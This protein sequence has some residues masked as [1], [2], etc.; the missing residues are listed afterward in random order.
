MKNFRFINLLGVF[1]V[2]LTLIGT[3]V[4]HASAGGGGFIYTVTSV[5][6]G[7][8]AN[9][10]D[11]ICDA[12]PGPG[13]VCTF[14]AAIEEANA[15]AAINTIFF[16]LPG[17]GMHYLSLTG[18][19]LPNIIAPLSIYG[20]SQPNCTV[21]CIVLSGASLGGTNDGLT[22]ATNGNYVRGLDIVSFGGAGINIMF[23]NGSLPNVIESNYIGFIPGEVVSHGNGEGIQTSASALN[24]V[25]GGTTASQRNVISGNIY[26]GIYLEGEATVVGNYI[27]TTPAGNAA[28]PNGRYGIAIGIDGSMNKI[29]GV[30]A[31]SGNIIAYNHSTGIAISNISNVHPMQNSIRRNSIFSNGGLGIDLNADGV[32]LNDLGDADV[33][34][35]GL[36][37]YPVLTGAVSSTKVIS[38]HLNS[39]ANKTYVIEFFSSHTCDPSSHGEGQT[40]IGTY[41]VT[42]NLSGNATYSHAV[43]GSFAS[44]SKITATA[45]DPGGNTSEFSVCYTATP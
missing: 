35:N 29:G 1:L 19:P 21:P 2:L 32:T 6:D 45:T 28:K 25:I 7:H 8:D 36:Q 22:L 44:G 33:G 43:T 26:D 15:D 41:S 12:D 14:R 16:K 31:G 18:S 40:Y 27:G 4:Q 17:S 30:A 24:T 3:S 13:V 34:A 20:Q 38:I 9:V 10:G 37:N 5:N 42:T 23:A 39:K 11:G